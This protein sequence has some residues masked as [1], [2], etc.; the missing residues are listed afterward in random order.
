MS[1]LEKKYI[2]EI[3]PALKKKFGYQN[4]LAVPRVIKVTVNAGL[5]RAHSEKDAQYAEMV[6]DNIAEITGQR[7]IK[8]LAKKSIAGFK[9]RKGLVVGV[10]TVLRSHKMYDFLTKLINVTL[11]RIRDFRGISSKSIDQRGNLSI[12][13]REQI[14]FPEISPEKAEKIHGLQVVITTN[15]P[16]KEE[17]KELF[18]LM[19]F[20]IKD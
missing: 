19:G 12:G 6:S 15:A 16:N 3:I 13:F 10:S 2:K 9:I 8:N 1:S 7:P 17:G 14:M 20:P 5:N 11:P 4:N 18:K